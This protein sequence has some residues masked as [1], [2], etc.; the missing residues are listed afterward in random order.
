MRLRF[1]PKCLLVLAAAGALGS[2]AAAPPP[3]RERGNATVTAVRS[4]QPFSSGTGVGGVAGAAVLGAGAA[5]ATGSAGTQRGA[6]GAGSQGIGGEFVAATVWE[7]TVEL[8]AGG[9]RVVRLD[10]PPP[11]GLG[12]RVLVTDERVERAR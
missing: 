6:V 9:E 7:V 5:A 10:R 8:D 12:A 3:A 4:L 11:Y 2:C 1:S